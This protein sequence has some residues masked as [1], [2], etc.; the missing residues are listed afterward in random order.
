VVQD[1]HLVSKAQSRQGRVS[2][3]VGGCHGIWLKLHGA[4]AFADLNVPHPLQGRKS[5]TL[6]R[7]LVGNLDEVTDVRWVGGPREDPSHLAVAT[8]CEVSRT[9]ENTGS[10]RVVGWACIW[11]AQPAK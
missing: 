4:H 10:A 1:K 2:T 6:S 7:Q 11:G 3:C 5:L 9:C 8:N